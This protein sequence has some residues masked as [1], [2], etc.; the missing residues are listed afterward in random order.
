MLRWGI[1]LPMQLIYQGKTGLCLPLEIE[2]PGGFNACYMENHWSN[3]EKVIE[4]L[5][6]VSF[7]FITSKRA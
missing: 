7:P 3:E 1:F 4:L 6:E 2:F 5:G